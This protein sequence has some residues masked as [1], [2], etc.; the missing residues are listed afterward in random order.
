MSE[1][2]TPRG[3]DLETALAALQPRP[4]EIDRDRLMFQAGL[5]AAAARCRRWQWSTGLMTAASLLLAAALVVRPGPEVRVVEIPPAPTPPAPAPV[6]VPE[7]APPAPVPEWPPTGRIQQALLQAGLQPGAPPSGQEVDD[8]AP[9]PP[10]HL[11]SAWQWRNDVT[12]HPSILD[13]GD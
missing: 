1:N 9:A 10:A 2:A 4:P 8:D 3:D 6:V 11:A 7:Q 12:L 5:A 13:E